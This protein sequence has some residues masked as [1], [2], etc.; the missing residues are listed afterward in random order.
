MVPAHRLALKPAMNILENHHNRRK[1]MKLRGHAAIDAKEL[2]P[3]VILN[4]Y[5]DPVGA[6]RENISLEE[7]RE[8][9]KEDPSLIWA[10]IRD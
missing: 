10:E 6:A 3:L 5:N 2:D 7:A 9:A 1:Y 8:I 4:K